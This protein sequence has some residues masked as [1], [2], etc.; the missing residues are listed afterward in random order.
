M[1]K[2]CYVRS[3][4]LLSTQRIPPS[5]GK[6]KLTKI[7]SAITKLC[8]L[9]PWTLVFFVVF[10]HKRN[11][12]QLL[13]P[14]QQ[15]RYLRSW[16]KASA[17]I[18]IESPLENIL[19]ERYKSKAW[20]TVNAMIANIA[21]S[22]IGLRRCRRSVAHAAL[23][24]DPNDRQNQLAAQHDRSLQSSICFCDYSWSLQSN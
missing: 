15:L 17:I 3:T 8:S 4:E 13:A 18:C 23:L 11:L 9:L 16:Q 10:C 12:W 2:C 1:C 24:D 21:L 6:G 5:A 20:P 14:H 22:A 7:A 19:L